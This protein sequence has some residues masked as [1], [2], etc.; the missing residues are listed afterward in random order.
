MVQS[1]L[2][3]DWIREMVQACLRSDRK[4]DVAVL[5]AFLQ[6]NDNNAIVSAF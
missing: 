1:C 3:S 6:D 2:R 5:S 4:G